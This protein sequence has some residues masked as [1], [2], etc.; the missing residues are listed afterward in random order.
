M[1]KKSKKMAFL[2]AGMTRRVYSLNSKMCIKIP[3]EGREDA[4]ILQN[5]A[6][7]ENMNLAFSNNLACFPRVYKLSD[8]GKELVM[9]KCESLPNNGLLESEAKKILEAAKMPLNCYT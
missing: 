4:T 3:I 7:F 6:E 8:N 2:G 9:Q 1:S 5:K